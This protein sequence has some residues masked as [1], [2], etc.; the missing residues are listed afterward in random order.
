MEELKKKAEHYDNQIKKL[1]AELL[2]TEEQIK[3]GVLKRGGEDVV[4]SIE[5][6]INAYCIM[7][8][9]VEKTINDKDVNN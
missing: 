4:K 9:K 6:T 1:E 2:Y 3:S 8:K 7:K 5:D